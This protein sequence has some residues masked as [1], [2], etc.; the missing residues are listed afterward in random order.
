MRLLLDTN[1]LIDILRKRE[2]YY[3]RARLLA[4][5]GYLGE[6][7]LWFSIS[8]ATDLMYVLTGGGKPSLAEGAKNDI[9]SLRSFMHVCSVGESHLD[10][11]AN[12]SWDDL[13]DALVYQAACSIK[14][15]AIITRNGT[16]FLKSSIRVFDCDS[17]F[18]F[19]R[20]DRGLDYEEIAI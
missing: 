6:F 16:D 15:D 7:E 5:L 10:W 19:M 14:A 4:A 1:I 18:D 8:Q 2:P 3:E 13:E 12:S 20:R 11:V 17:F 9:R